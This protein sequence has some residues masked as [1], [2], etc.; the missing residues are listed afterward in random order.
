M[1]CNLKDPHARPH[2]MTTWEY[3]F[4]DLYRQNGEGVR[5]VAAELIQAGLEGWEAVGEID[6]L[7]SG[8]H[9]PMILLKRPR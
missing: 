9:V 8:A 4:I 2:N 6:V 5:N 1:T 3:Y 7:M